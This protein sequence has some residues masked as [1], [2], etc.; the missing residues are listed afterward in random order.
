MDVTYVD[1]DSLQLCKGRTVAFHKLYLCKDPYQTKGTCNNK[2][3]Y[4]ENYSTIAGGLVVW[5]RDGVVR[6]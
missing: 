3:N 2:S 4:I 1:K 5:G 6:W